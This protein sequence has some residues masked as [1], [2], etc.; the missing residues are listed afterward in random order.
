MEQL[1]LLGS[2]VSTEFQ[3]S[4]KIAIYILRIPPLRILTCFERVKEEGG[5]PKRGGPL[6]SDTPERSS[7]SYQ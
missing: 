1:P 6:G 3:M 4:R 2:F 5:K 7:V